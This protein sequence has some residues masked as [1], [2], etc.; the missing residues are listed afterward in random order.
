M[1]TLTLIHSPPPTTATPASICD[2][3]FGSFGNDETYIGEGWAPPSP[4]YRRAS[5]ER[6]ELWLDHPP[7][8]HF[9]VLTIGLQL[10]SAYKNQ[11]EAP[12]NVAVRGLTV[13]SRA[14]PR[15]GKLAIVIPAELVA[16]RGP[17]RVTLHGENLAVRRVTLNTLDPAA[18]PRII[19]GGGMTMPT[20]E[21]ARGVPAAK[22]TLGF[23][24]LGNSC[25]FG[26]IQ[27]ACGAEPLS[28]FRYAAIPHGELLRALRSGFD[29]FGR[30]QNLS[31]YI[32]TDND[33]RQFYDIVDGHYDFGYHT[34]IAVGEVPE[35]G[36]LKQ[37]SRYLK[38]LTRK[39]TQELTEGRK[40]FIYRNNDPVPLQDILHLHNAMTAHGP[41]TLLWVVESDAYPS[42]T[43]E[44]M[45]PRL[46]RGIIARLAPRWDAGQFQ[47]EPWLE[48]CHNALLLT[49]TCAEAGQAGP[50]AAAQ[51]P[52][53]SGAHVR[54]LGD[55]WAWPHDR[56][57]EVGSGLRIEALNILPP[58]DAPD[59][60]FTY[61]ARFTDGALSEWAA[62]GEICGS[63]GENRGIAGIEL[64]LTGAG[65][66]GYTCAYDATF[67]DGTASGPVPAGALC[68]AAEGGAAE[69]ESFRITV[70]KRGVK[71]APVPAQI[72]APA[73]SAEFPRPA[74]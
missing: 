52:V 69:L 67:T 15:F 41:A 5:A 73:A 3:V 7:P 39:L 66:A 45:M 59:V 8:A 24:S 51:L 71:W 61:R 16:A 50:A 4:G 74:T 46:I 1:A 18:L 58:L 10:F 31:P 36:L 11:P 48:V 27:R 42:G 6:C 35:D 54:D 34:N 33:G 55:L 9:Y 26:F 57:G 40:I 72:S 44:L 17:V 56:I 29:G 28:L 68:T 21:H 19:G 43:V 63:R 14:A 53:A 23:E 64:R 70:L 65:A 30:L 2:I 22:F 25:E 49:E 12:F 20:L 62:A 13:S 37:Q 47:L 32:R 38:L 60:S